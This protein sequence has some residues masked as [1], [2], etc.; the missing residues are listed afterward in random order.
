MKTKDAALR[1]IGL[2]LALAVA[3]C[4][5]VI[6]AAQQGPPVAA[7]GPAPVAR[8]ASPGDA[9]QV[10]GRWIIDV[11]NPDGTLASHHDFQNALLPSGQQLLSYLISKGSSIITWDIRLRANNTDPTGPCPPSPTNDSSCYIAGPGST[12]PLLM[13]NAPNVFSTGA[14]TRTPAGTLEIS[15]NATAASAQSIGYVESLAEAT[16]LQVSSFS[17]RVL[18]TPIQV[19]VG[20]QLFVKVIVSFTA[21]EPPPGGGGGGLDSDGDGIPDTIDVCPAVPNVLYNGVQYCPE[22]IYDAMRGTVPLNAAIELQSMTV[23]DVTASTIT[24]TVL[25]GDPAYNT[26]DGDTYAS[27]VV[28][29]N[30]LTAPAV[31]NVVTIFG[32]LVAYGTPPYPPPQNTPY[33]PGLVSAAAVQVTSAF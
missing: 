15:G 2:S 6:L 3:L 5:T 9:I 27:T 30:G 23:T 14:F 29:L 31:G 25:P 8:G 24:V 10:H 32:T 1:G 17:A 12:L 18:D 4:A 7:R 28:Q 22:S 11:R 33:I 19:A 20:Q 13:P 16:G 21:T 26:N